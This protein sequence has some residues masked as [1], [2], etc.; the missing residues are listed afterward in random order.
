MIK[1]LLLFFVLLI[2]FVSVSTAQTYNFKVDSIKIRQPR[3]FDSLGFVSFK[4]TPI[5]PG[6]ACGSYQVILEK[7][8][9]P[10]NIVIRSRVIATL[11][12]TFNNLPPLAGYIIRVSELCSPLPIQKLGIFTIIPVSKAVA[13][14]RRFFPKCFGQNAKIIIDTIIG[15]TPYSFAQAGTKFP[16]NFYWD[17][18][19]F[20]NNDSVVLLPGG[21]SLTIIDSLGCISLDTNFRVPNIKKISPKDTSFPVICHNDCNAQIK[22]LS[23]SAVPPVLY[24]FINANTGL[25]V[26]GF[27]LNNIYTSA[28]ADS[29]YK[30]ILKDSNNCIDTSRLI[31]IK[32]PPLLVLDTLNKQNLRCTPGCDGKITLIPSGGTSIKPGNYYQ[33]TVVKGPTDSLKVFNLPANVPYVFDSLCA[34]NYELKIRDSAGCEKTITFKINPPSNPLKITAVGTNIKCA[35]DKNGKIKVNV[36]SGLGRFKY[37]YLRLPPLVGC[38]P[39]FTGIA[40]NSISDSIVNLCPGKYEITVTDSFLCVKKDTITITQ[41]DSLKIKIKTSSNPKCYGDANGVITVGATGGTKPYSFSWNG[42][43]FALDSSKNTLVGGINTIIVR[44]ANLCTATIT[45]TLVDPDSISLKF[46]TKREKC[47]GLNDGQ[48]IALASGGTRPFSYAW[49]PSIIFTLLDSTRNNLIPNTY[50]VTVKDNNACQKIGTF[51]IL[52]ALPFSVNLAVAKPN[53]S[54]A[55]CDGIIKSTISGGKAPFIYSWSN[56]TLGTPGV[57]I[58]SNNDSI[59]NLCS[60]YYALKVTDSAGC[61]SNDRDTLKP[62]IKLTVVIT[63][64]PLTCASPTSGSAT[65]TV[66]NGSPGFTIV[67]TKLPNIN[68]PPTTATATTSTVTN[69]GAG[70]Y[71]ATVTDFYNC[72]TTDTAKFLPPPK[73]AFTLIPSKPKCFGGNTGFINATFVSGKTPFSTVR[74]SRITAPSAILYQNTSP[75]GLPIP[76]PNGLISGT[77]Q[78]YI[79]DAN[80]CDSTFTAII[81]DTNKIVIQDSVLKLPDCIA[82]PTLQNGSIKLTI[83]GGTLTLAIPNYIITWKEIISGTSYPAFNNLKTITGIGPG[84][85]RAIVEDGNACKDS[86]TRTLSNPTSISFTVQPVNAQCHNTKSGSIAIVN[87]NMAVLPG[88]L[89]IFNITTG[90]PVSVFTLPINT[91]TFNTASPVP[92]SKGSYIV[93]V[94]DGLGC[95]KDSNII[96]TASS[97]ISV[98]PILN[99]PKCHNDVNGKILIVNT[100]PISPSGGNGGPYTS[101][102]FSGPVGFTVPVSNNPS[103]PANLPGGVFKYFVVDNFGCRDTFSAT[104]VNPTILSGTFTLKKPIVCYGD[105]NAVGYITP[106]G[107]TPSYINYGWPNGVITDT[108]Y[109]LKADTFNLIFRDAN[110]CTASVL[111]QISQPAKILATIKTDSVKCFGTATGKAQVLSVSGGNPPFQYAWNVLPVNNTSANFVNNVFAGTHQLLITDLVTGCISTNPF[112]IKQNPKIIITLN[113]TNAKCFGEPSG[114]ASAVVSGGTGSLTYNYIWKKLSSPNVYPNA[115]NVSGLTAGSYKLIVSDINGCSDSTSFAIT[116][117]TKINANLSIL[118]PLIC[119][120]DSNAKIISAPTGGTGLLYDFSWTK[121]GILKQT[122]FNQKKDTLFSGFGK[123]IV[124]VTDSV[125]CSIKDSITVSN[126]PII[127][128]STSIVNPA[129][130]DSTASVGA[131]QFTLSGGTI[132]YSYVWSLVPPITAANIA[133][134]PLPNLGAAISIATPIF[135][136]TALGPGP[137]FVNITDANGCKLSPPLVVEPSSLNS[138]KID[139][140]KTYNNVCFGDLNGAARVKLASGGT[141]PYIYSWLD[142]LNVVIPPAT[143]ATDSVNGLKSG[144]YKAVIA[145]VTGCTSIDTFYILGP[146]KMMSNLLK[147]PPLCKGKND[148]SLIVTKIVGTGTGAFSF[149]LKLNPS[150]SF[151]NPSLLPGTFN[152][153]ATGSYTLRMTDLTSGCIQDSTFFF[154]PQIEI[155]AQ[156]NASDV[157]CFGDKT[158]AIA[159]SSVTGGAIPPYSYQWNDPSGQATSIANNLAAGIYNVTVTDGNGCV[160]T[161]ADTVLEK[162]VIK[163]SFTITNAACKQNTGAINITNTSGGKPAYTFIWNNNATTSGISALF[164]GVYTVTIKD[165]LNCTKQFSASINDANGPSVVETHTN[166]NCYGANNGSASVVA[167][168]KAPFIY[169]WLPSGQAGFTSIS[170]LGAGNNYIVQVKDSNGCIGSDTFSITEPAPLAL[171]PVSTASGCGALQTGK[172]VLLVSGGTGPYNYNWFAPIASTGSVVSNLSAG[173]Y[174]VTV[175]DANACTSTQYIAVN[176][177]NGP[178]VTLLKQDQKCATGGT[179]LASLNA[180]GGA[181]PY[182]YAWSGASGS[183]N[184]ISGLLPNNYGYTVTDNNQCVA[185]GL[186]TIKPGVSPQLS[187]PRIVTPRCFDSCNASI[188]HI[189]SAGTLPYTFTWS[190]TPSP[191]NTLGQSA[192]RLCAGIYTFT[193]T[194]N[195][196]CTVS[197]KDTLKNPPPLALS[198]VVDSIICPLDANGKITATVTGGTPNYTYAWSTGTAVGN[199]SSGISAGPVSLV[200]TDANGCKIDTAVTL[201]PSIIIQPNA[202]P[203]IKTCPDQTVALTAISNVPAETFSWYTQIGGPS[204]GSG[205]TINVQTPTGI[206]L[207]TYILQVMNKTCKAFDTVQLILPEPLTDAGPDKEIVLGGNVTIGGNPTGPVSGNGVPTTYLW[208]PNDFVNNATLA[209]PN[210]SPLQTNNY[211]VAVT[212]D[213][214]T[215]LDTMRVTVVPTIVVPNGLTPNGDGLNDTWELTNIEKFP[216]NQ[217]EIFNRWGEQLYLKKGYN[218]VNGWNGKYNNQDLPVG[219]YYFVIK[220]NDPIFPNPITGPITILR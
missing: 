104:L 106:T 116:A 27:S 148:G 158:G 2:S 183:G 170:G 141:L 119:F 78:L 154:A 171:N 54:G 88:T 194:D 53:C 26:Q 207:V 1:K 153:L 71:V 83:T 28:C 181:L 188:A 108:A 30:V 187:I 77:Y 96:I 92:L 75:V 218:N 197:K 162:P 67:W 121:N 215:F 59:F 212:H 87:G 101:T 198:I 7:P 69:L 128:V 100:S 112:V 201:S 117:P 63:S 8:G 102:I 80:G 70:T 113:V 34:G 107:G 90:S 130:C 204:I 168:G 98:T 40:T 95:I 21:H 146:S 156:L 22:I 93:R 19:L 169:N 161:F 133:K 210:V 120:G 79:V 47:A 85:Y 211:V 86:I 206:Y 99:N 205:Q 58:I 4:I 11:K 145:D 143:L 124:T 189:S 81:A 18:N 217:V 65:A 56:V 196:N 72:V 219:T 64:G 122:K 94:Q 15:G 155:K 144:M 150:G 57:P 175:T 178:V 14:S 89:T 126:A 48:V 191:T 25:P 105:S 3:C 131:I 6:V 134:N 157:N 151:V 103:L 186:F 165:A 91:N 43:A 172:I 159:V 39:V 73:V 44:D 184:S 174:K 97:P 66:T 38:N 160:A 135:T 195:N 111:V 13:T 202:G 138:P 118:S 190:G 20:F 127:T 142:P 37:T 140:I 129:K 147:T 193:V 167:T 35:G 17:N 50:S 109:G 51:V 125:G 49:A 166:I 179:G 136:Q 74:W 62:A 42:G 214:C 10:T 41:P 164:A 203:D 176:S 76:N 32:N 110:L 123:I 23:S 152:N 208:S 137:Y 209:N 139:S 52:P 192:T 199:I 216:N 180:S 84:T 185:A 29:S 33:V 16:Y 31:K 55:L 5:S 213:G 61:V 163:A 82:N 9:F 24:Q 220:L 68:I 60:G 46:I 132:P 36:I 12:D 115:A 149:Q 182:T 114:I 177:I 173:I 45:K 200:A